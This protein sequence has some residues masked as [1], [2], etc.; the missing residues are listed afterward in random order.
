MALVHRGHFGQPNRRA[1]VYIPISF[2][3]VP[4]I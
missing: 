1:I 3:T 2:S 4:S